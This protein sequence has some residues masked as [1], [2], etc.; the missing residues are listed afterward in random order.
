MYALLCSVGDCRAAPSLP[1]L[2]PAQHA[3]QPAVLCGTRRGEGAASMACWHLRKECIVQGWMFCEIPFLT[4]FT[5]YIQRVESGA[6][7]SRTQA[8]KAKCYLFLFFEWWILISKGATVVLPSLIPVP[9]E[10]FLFERWT[11]L[12]Y[13]RCVWLLG[14]SN[15]PLTCSSILLKNYQAWKLLGNWKP[16]WNQIRGT[17]VPSDLTRI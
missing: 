7:T 3:P 16:G 10:H 14:F 11:G 4:S 13:C 6:V 2:A 5:S 17:A 12:F 15:W 8:G 1:F 9:A